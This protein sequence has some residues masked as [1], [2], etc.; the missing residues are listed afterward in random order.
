MPKPA[1]RFN[2]TSAAIVAVKPPTDQERVYVCDKRTP[3]QLSGSSIVSWLHARPANLLVCQVL[4]RGR[5]K[6]A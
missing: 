6:K 1:T 2:F 3:A 5:H 4:S